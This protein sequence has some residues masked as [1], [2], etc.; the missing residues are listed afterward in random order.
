MIQFMRSTSSAAA[1]QAPLLQAGQPFYE[2]DTHKLKIGDGSTAWNDLPYIG[3]STSLTSDTKIIRIGTSDTHVNDKY[4]EN[5][6]TY[7]C[8][9]TND[10]VEFNTAISDLNITGGIILVYSGSYN[11][12]NTVTIPDDLNIDIIGVG[13]PI[14][15][16]Y[17]LSENVPLFSLGNNSRINQCSFINDS[18]GKNYLISANSSSTSRDE[19][20]GCSIKNCYFESRYSGA[21]IQVTSEIV[22]TDC[23]FLAYDSEA[24]DISLSHT[25]AGYC[26]ISNNIFTSKNT[27]TTTNCAISI[28]GRIADI[29]DA[30]NIMTIIANNVA[31]NIAM[32]INSPGNSVIVSNNTIAVTNYGINIWRQQSMGEN[33]NKYGVVVN[34][35]YVVTMD[36]SKLSQGICI[37]TDRS[38]CVGNVIL[39]FTEGIR[40]TGAYCTVTGN[41]V[42]GTI[43][44]DGENNL[45]AQNTVN[46]GI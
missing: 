1:S 36:S 25:Q 38:T 12:S 29:E 10:E 23:K 30:K 2:T 7:M 18:S 45:V 26:I 27:T 5:M 15:Y 40:I 4:S 20:H 19:A 11:F 22:I 35:N 41:T 28:S 34:N 6:V 14:F 16:T 44:D 33:A 31:R 17:K 46:A 43:G 37:G 39:N 8:D 32:F 3:G 24:I 13:T 21:F 9:G 42:S